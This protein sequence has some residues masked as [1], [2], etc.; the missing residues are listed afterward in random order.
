M[1]DIAV[2]SLVLVVQDKVD[3]VVLDMMNW[4]GDIAH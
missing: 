2:H 3:I 1:V 4:E